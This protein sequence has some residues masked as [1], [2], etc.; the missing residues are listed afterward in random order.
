M[1]FQLVDSNPDE[2]KFC[3]EEAMPDPGNITM[4][5]AF[6]S[7]LGMRGGLRHWSVSP[8]DLETGEQA[9]KFADYYDYASPGNPPHSVHLGMG[10][11]SHSEIRYSDFKQQLNDTEVEDWLASHFTRSAMYDVSD[12]TKCTADDMVIDAPPILSGFDEDKDSVDWYTSKMLEADIDSDYAN[13]LDDTSMGEYWG[14][15]S[16]LRRLL[17]QHTGNSGDASSVL[18]QEEEFREPEV[19]TSINIDLADTWFYREVGSLFFGTEGT[20]TDVDSFWQFLFTTEPELSEGV[21]LAGFKSRVALTSGLTVDQL[22]EVPSPVT[23]ATKATVQHLADSPEWLTATHRSLVT[24]EDFIIDED[25]YVR[26]QEDATGCSATTYR[27]VGL[28]DDENPSHFTVDARTS[29]HQPEGDN[30]DTPAGQSLADIGATG[31]KHVFFFEDYDTAAAANCDPGDSLPSAGR[32]QLAEAAADIEATGEGSFDVKTEVAAR[33]SK[34]R[35]RR[36]SRPPPPPFNPNGYIPTFSNGQIAKP[37]SW[38]GSFYGS[39]GGFDWE[40]VT[41]PDDR[42][43]LCG[44]SFTFEFNKESGGVLATFAD[45][46]GGAVTVVAGVNMMGGSWTQGTQSSYWATRS[47]GGR[48]RVT[49]NTKCRRGFEETLSLTLEREGKPPAWAGS[50]AKDIDTTNSGSITLTHGH[51]TEAHGGHSLG[52]AQTDANFIRITG[53]LSQTHSLKTCKAAGRVGAAGAKL[54]VGAGIFV[55]TL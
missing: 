6:M 17:A 26:L 46:L 28:P 51:C 21:D 5:N 53:G 44:A 18:Q 4:E 45:K 10:D 1:S 23:Y 13:M 33:V 49:T 27:V 42:S 48:Y 22:N 20:L 3:S 7:F 11:E 38:G 52:S 36:R 24:A 25:K 41:C 15:V 30:D 29:Q 9:D 47:N 31:A 8:V 14:A 43:K 16:Y 19:Q 35:R 55:S 50:L 37:S 39:V 34:G 54:Y 2:R 12:L 40:A 32:R